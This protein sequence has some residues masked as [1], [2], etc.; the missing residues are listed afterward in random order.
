MNSLTTDSHDPACITAP[1]RGA[2]ASGG[3]AFLRIVQIVQQK[4]R[5]ASSGA[6]FLRFDPTAPGTDPARHRMPAVALTFT[7]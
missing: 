3:A 5:L 1:V 2:P 6:S 4:K 7:G